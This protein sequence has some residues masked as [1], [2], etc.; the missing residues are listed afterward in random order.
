MK[1]EKAGSGLPKNEQLFIKLFLVP[2][3]RVVI[4]WNKVTKKI[5]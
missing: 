4:N 3:V 5:V 1:F 2:F